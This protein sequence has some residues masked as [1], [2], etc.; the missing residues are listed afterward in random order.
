VANT[1]R[2]RRAPEKR[3]PANWPTAKTCR[4]DVGTILATSPSEITTNEGQTNNG[5]I[6]S[7][8]YRLSLQVSGTSHGRETASQRSRDGAPGSRT[9]SRGISLPLGRSAARSQTISMVTQCRT[10]K[11]PNTSMATR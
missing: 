8:R 1:D 3:A 11:S 4:G 2:V 10:A 9:N 6:V 5:G 7:C